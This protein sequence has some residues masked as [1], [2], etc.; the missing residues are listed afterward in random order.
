MKI[1]GEIPK[2][3]GI[4]DKQKNVKKV[5]KTASVVSKRDVVSISNSARDFQSIMKSLK[6]VPDVR[7][8]KVNDLKGKYE[9]GNYSI[10]GKEISDKLI[11]S[12]FDKKA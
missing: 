4:Y 10:S 8:D 3:L 6:E 5:D 1:W 2:I 9:T 11:N 7:Q 12:V